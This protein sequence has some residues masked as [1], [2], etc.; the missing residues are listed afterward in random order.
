MAKLQTPINYN[1]E[2]NSY[3]KL[4]FSFWLYFIFV[5]IVMLLT[6]TTTDVS[7][8]FLRCVPSLS[9]GTCGLHYYSIQLMIRYK[10]KSIENCFR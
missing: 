3:I 8:T 6:T 5:V 7:Y 2:F 4:N 1:P 9:F 10:I